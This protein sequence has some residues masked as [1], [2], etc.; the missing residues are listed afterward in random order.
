MKKYVTSYAREVIAK[1]DAA[2]VLKAFENPLET[3]R[4]VFASKLTREMREASVRMGRSVARLEICNHPYLEGV[5]S[6]KFPGTYPVVMSVLCKCLGISQTECA[7][8]L[9][10]SEVSSMMLSAIRLGKV[11]FVAGHR[12]LNS[13]LGSVTI[14]DVYSPFSPLSDILSIQHERRE[15]KVFMS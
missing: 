5:N 2:A 9:F 12:F 13:L 1:G 14:S 7:S 15:P 8:G 11:D 3:D 4:I 10:Y 6:G